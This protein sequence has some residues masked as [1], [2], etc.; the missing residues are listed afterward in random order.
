MPYATFPK[1]T[2]IVQLPTLSTC[3][4]RGQSRIGPHGPL[5]L[6]QQPR[7]QPGAQSVLDIAQKPECN[8]PSNYTGLILY[9][10]NSSNK[11]FPSQIQSRDRL[12]HTFRA[13][14]ESCLAQNTAHSAG[15][16][17]NAVPTNSRHQDVVRVCDS[18]GPQ[19]TQGPFDKRGNKLLTKY[20]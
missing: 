4:K 18:P 8:N 14:K 11:L 5:K 15:S 3:N 12:N 16:N 1:I 9:N 20:W 19:V 13:N 6:A 17:T 10:D 7:T 2:K